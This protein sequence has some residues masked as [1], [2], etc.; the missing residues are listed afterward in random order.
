MTEQLNAWKGQFGQD[1]TD[2]N[3]IDWRSREPAFRHMVG[4]L[5]IHRTLEVGCNRGHNLVALSHVFPESREVVGVEPNPHA[6][7]IARSASNKVGVLDGSIFDLPFKDSFFDL[8]FTAGVLIHVSPGELSAAMCEIY[9][10]SR[11]YLLTVEYFSE[12]EQVI[13]YR[14]HGDLLWKRNFLRLYQSQFPNLRLIRSGFWDVD[15]GFDRATWWLLERQDKTD[16][17]TT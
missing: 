3:V 10:V 13:Q 5:P 8:V 16:A 6:L 4:D 1:Y 14:G 7:E 2:R 17:L 9:R 15:N 11:R 12:E